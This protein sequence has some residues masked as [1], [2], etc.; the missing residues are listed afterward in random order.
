MKTLKQLALLPLFFGLVLTTAC[1]ENY[2]NGNGNGNGDRPFNR[3]I[4]AQVVNGNNYDDI[5][6]TVAITL[7]DYDDRSHTVATG[8]WANDGFTITLP[9]TINT[10]LL[11]PIF[12]YEQGLNLSDTLARWR[13]VW[14]RAYDEQQRNR[15]QFSYW[16]GDGDAYSGLYLFYVDRDVTI[17]GTRPFFN[18]SVY[19]PPTIGGYEVWNVQLRA[20]WNRI[21][22]KREERT[23]YNISTEPISGLRWHFH[24]SG[25]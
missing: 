5:I 8:T 3:T 2:D 14:V 24:Y 13:D 1:T 18:E 23:L 12:Y 9:E 20:G 7:W 22:V 6:S 10:E 15:G 19:G 11:Y 4:T 16:S 17:T 21:Y 25:Q